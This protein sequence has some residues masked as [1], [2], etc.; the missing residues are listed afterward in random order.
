[1]FPKF[2]VCF[3]VNAKTKRRKNFS[4]ERVKWMFVTPT[5]LSSVQP[6]TELIPQRKRTAQPI[7]QLEV[8]S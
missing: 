5:W 3:E 1:M 7:L 8:P 2:E 6:I 4:Q